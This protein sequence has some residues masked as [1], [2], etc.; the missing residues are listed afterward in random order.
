MLS[1]APGRPRGA[2][3]VA[4]EEEGPAIGEGWAEGSWDEMVEGWRLLDNSEGIVE[5]RLDG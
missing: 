1:T 3:G 4:A 2:C 5:G